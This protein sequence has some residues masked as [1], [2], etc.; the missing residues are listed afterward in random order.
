VARGRDEVVALA[1]L[2]VV[3][4]L[5]L[6]VV[7]ADAFVVGAEAVAL[8]RGLSP[9]VVGAV[10]VGFG[11]SLPELVTSV[12]AA[13]AGEPDLAVGNAAGSNVANLLLILGVAALVAPIGRARPGPWRG[14]GRDAAVAAV[15]G[16]VLLGLAVDGRVGPVDALMLLA[17]LAACVTWQVVSTRTV[18]LEVAVRPPGRAV[19]WRAGAGLV[20]VLAGAQ[21]LVWGATSLA[22]EAGVPP[23]VVGSLLVAV[24]TSLPELATAVASARR[25][26]TELLIGNLLGSNAF[27]ALGVV[28]ASAAVA[29]ARADV[30]VV[31]PAALVVVVGAAATTAV[32]AAGLWW[33]PRVGRVT[34][35][36]L[37]TAYAATVPVLLTVS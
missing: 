25:G 17:V 35:A 31:T 27:N 13:A 26:Q 23:I 36:A 34:G 11:T 22:T 14:P 19:G 30:L 7:A 12:L 29:A 4:G 32:V 28:G 2:A 15:A 10:V 3:V 20:G 18:P 21:A 8:R 24:G 6:L 9:T 5:G 16:L 37:V 33:R 1:V